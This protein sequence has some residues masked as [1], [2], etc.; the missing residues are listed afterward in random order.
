MKYVIKI[1]D[2][3]NDKEKTYISLKI[4][5]EIRKEFLYENTIFNSQNLNLFNSKSE[6]KNELNILINDWKRI[7]LSNPEKDIE[8]YFDEKEKLHISFI[9]EFGKK[10][11]IFFIDEYK[12]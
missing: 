2:V 1:K 5:D 8:F 3:L 7:Q 9:N 12:I 11:F 4:T 10:Y 6:A